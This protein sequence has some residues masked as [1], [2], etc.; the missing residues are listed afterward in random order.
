MGAGFFNSPFNL[1]AQAQAQVRFASAGTGSRK[2]RPDI[3]AW[4]SIWAF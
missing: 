2:D 4:V 1:E 3:P